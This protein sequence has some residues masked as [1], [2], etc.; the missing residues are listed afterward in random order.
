MIRIYYGK[1][2]TDSAGFVFAESKRMVDEGCSGALILVPDRYT[3][4]MEKKAFSALKAEGLMDIEIMSFSRMAS[5]LIPH[6]EGVKYIDDLSRAMILRKVISENK[7]A[8][9]LFARSVGKADF[10]RMMGDIIQDFKQFKTTPLDVVSVLETGDEN[11]ASISS[12]LRKKLKEIGLIYEAYE[13]EIKDRFF[14][15]EDYLERLCQEIR[16]SESLKGKAVFVLGFDFFSERLLS[17]LEEIDKKCISLT[18]ILLAGKSGEPDYSLFAPVNK[19]IKDVADVARRAGEK[20]IYINEVPADFLRDQ[21]EEIAH[22]GRN[23]YAF[24]KERFY[25]DKPEDIMAFSCDTRE[26]ETVVAARIIKDLVK[27]HGLRFK[28]IGVAVSDLDS[29]EGLIRR[30]F[31]REGIK[32]F[33]DSKYA[34]ADNKFMQFLLALCDLESGY[35][36]GEDLMRIAGTGVFDINQDEKEVLENYAYKYKI[37]NY[38][39]QRPFYKIDRRRKEEGEAE[40]AA[41]A[42]IEEAS[43]AEGNNE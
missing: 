25:Y 41:N 21:N 26:T 17:V 37:E 38:Q 32:Y 42:A 15:T 10:V 12:M 24:P 30:T 20:G 31:D 11:E 14:D 29:R 2:N 36:H 7:E 28:D 9:G 43:E 1:N 34:A 3:L 33:D 18:V 19:S 16:T 13:E 8:L 40:A 35:G 23:L 6:S 39:W 5:K 22:L 4:E 27:N